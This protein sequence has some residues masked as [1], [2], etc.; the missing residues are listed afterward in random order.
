MLLR[1]GAG[2]AHASPVFLLSVRRASDKPPPKID[3]YGGKNPNDPRRAST[4]GAG[5][6][7]A[8]P[9]NVWTASS[10][11]ATESVSQDK[12]APET[13]AE[14][15]AWLKKETAGWTPPQ[16]GDTFA[17]HKKRANIVHVN[18]FN[19]PDVTEADRKEE[20]WLQKRQR[21]LDKNSDV[22][23]VGSGLLIGMYFVYVIYCSV[24]RKADE[25]PAKNCYIGEMVELTLSVDGQVFKEPVVVGLFTQRAP[26]A[27]ENFRR[28]ATGDNTKGL[29]LTDLPFF[30][31]ESHA[32]YGGV[33]EGKDARGGVIALD[34]L[35]ARL[36]QE[37]SEL[38][39][40]RYALTS[41]KRAFYS[42]AG[43]DSTFA[44]LTSGL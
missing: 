4:Y 24:T 33:E 15:K 23:F 27:C 22:V 29:S 5:Q 20:A 7:S 43:F 25:H 18:F 32:L 8:I 11:A 13:S 6:R 3:E 26:A 37:D 16:K 2:H 36:P 35:G 21:E 38:P 44:I 40:F 1:R 42:N 39:P 30:R 14:R 12:R 34:G 19:E 31:I 28:L 9:D 10:G 17:D 41:C